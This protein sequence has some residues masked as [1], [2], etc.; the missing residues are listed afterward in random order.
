MVLAT[1]PFFKEKLENSEFFFTIKTNEE[2]SY[3]V[4]MTVL[5]FIYNDEVKSFA[6]KSDFGFWF[7]VFKMSA[8]FQLVKLNDLCQK[9]LIKLY[10]KCDINLNDKPGVM[11]DENN[12]HIEFV[13]TLIQNRKESDVSEKVK[14]LIVLINQAYLLKTMKFLDFLLTEVAQKTKYQSSELIDL[15]P[16]LK[17]R[18]DSCRISEAISYNTDVID[19]L[20]DTFP[21]QFELTDT[22]TT[23]DSLEMWKSISKLAFPKL[24]KVMNGKKKNSDQTIKKVLLEEEKL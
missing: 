1:C 19:S 15:N 10:E 14:K 9:E 2:Y 6:K 13:E 8:S 7:D 24:T 17:V 18:F 5:S 22:M 16:D 3:E 11:L 23:S 21:F 4:I 20:K 12:P